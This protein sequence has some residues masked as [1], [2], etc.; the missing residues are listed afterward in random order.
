MINIIH[1][2]IKKSYI[3]PFCGGIHYSPY[4]WLNPEDFQ[5]R[6]GL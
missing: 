2:D 3:Y 1:M 4:D 5:R 6:N